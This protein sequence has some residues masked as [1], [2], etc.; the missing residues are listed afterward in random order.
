VSASTNAVAT[1]EGGSAHTI[2][3]TVILRN[4]NQGESYRI[5]DSTLIVVD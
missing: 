5:D 2:C 4:F 3:A 1:L